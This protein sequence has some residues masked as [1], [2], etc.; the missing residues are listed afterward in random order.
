MKRPIDIVAY[1]DD[2]NL[3][4]VSWNQLFLEAVQ[5]EYRLTHGQAVLYR[6]VAQNRW[7]LV[8]C[9]YGIAVLILPPVD[10]EAR[11]TL[12]LEISRF[13]RKFSTGFDAGMELLDKEIKRNKERTARMHNKKRTAK[14]TVRR[15]RRK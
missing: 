2:A 14:L 11:L 7:R 9:F 10:K 1:E 8:A 6:N 4:E 15:G 13:L 5:T 3:R 12:D